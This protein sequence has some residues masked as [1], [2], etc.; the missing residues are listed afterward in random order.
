M[1]QITFFTDT[2]FVTG[3]VIIT[4]GYTCMHIFV[5]DKG[6]VKVYPMKSQ[7]GYPAELRQFAKDI[8]APYILVCDLTLNI[9]AK[10]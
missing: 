10:N 2:F 8:G 6:F 7:S 9:G 3:K 5:S 1:D 4:Q